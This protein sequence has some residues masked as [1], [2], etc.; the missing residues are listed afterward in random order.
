MVKRAFTHKFLQSTQI[1]VNLGVD[2]PQDKLN[3]TVNKMI[4]K[5]NS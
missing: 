4:G 5:A 1:Y 2:D 3:D